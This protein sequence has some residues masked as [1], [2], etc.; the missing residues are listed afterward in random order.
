MYWEKELLK[1]VLS[2][3]SYLEIENR[4]RRKVRDN[5]KDTVIWKDYR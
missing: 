5:L 2:I 1:S 3:G 4:D